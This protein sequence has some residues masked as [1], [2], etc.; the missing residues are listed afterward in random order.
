MLPGTSGSRI[1]VVEPGPPLEIAL[2]ACA[3]HYQGGG[4]PRLMRFEQQESVKRE[5]PAPGV[6]PYERAQRYHEIRQP[7]VG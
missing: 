5:A 7:T 1:G 3:K 2:A 4:D 6:M